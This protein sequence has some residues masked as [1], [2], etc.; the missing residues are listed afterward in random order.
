MGEIII[1]NTDY[2]DKYSE[3]RWER[4]FVFSENDGGWVIGEQMIEGVPWYVISLDHKRKL[5]LA[6]EDELAY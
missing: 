4:T 1:N 6:T 5:I 2:V 3:E